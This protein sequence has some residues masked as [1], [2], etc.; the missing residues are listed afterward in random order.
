ML[1]PAP[2][3]TVA[4]GATGV[5]A[6]MGA[7]AMAVLRGIREVSLREAHAQTAQ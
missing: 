2:L 7:A 6:A 4:M 3:A 5:T 1:T